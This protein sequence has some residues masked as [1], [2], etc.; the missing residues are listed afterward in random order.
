MSFQGEGGSI[1]TSSAYYPLVDDVGKFPEEVGLDP[2]TSLSQIDSM[3]STMIQP[4]LRF[5]K[6]ST[7]GSIGEKRTRLMKFIGVSHEMAFG[8]K[9]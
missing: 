8:V 6:L 1:G 2:L 7:T 3:N 9:S 4:Y 5:Y